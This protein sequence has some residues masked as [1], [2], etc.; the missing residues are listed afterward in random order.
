[1]KLNVIDQIVNNDL[2]IGCGICTVVCPQK[3]LSIQF[4]NYG[5]YIAV[6][7]NNCT[8]ECGLCLKVC[9]FSDGNMN[10]TYLGAQIFNH[11]EKIKFLPETGYYLD[12]YVGYSTQFRRNGASGGIATWLLTTL[13][14]NDI[15]D[16][17]ICATPHNDPEKLFKLEIFDNAFSVFNSSGSVYYPLEMSQVIQKVLDKSGRYAIT[18]LPCFLKS[19]RLAAQKNTK[20]GERIVISIGLVCGQMKSKYYT[21]YLSELAGVSGELQKVYYRGKNPDKPANNYYFYCM[22][23]NGFEGKIFWDSGVSEAWVNRWF[24]PN[25]CNFCD[26]VFAELADVTVM[27]AWLPE[28]SY[29]NSGTNLVL[30]RSPIV[31]EMISKGIECDEIN[32][33]KISIDKL[34]QS[35]A[36]VL[37]IKR[38]HLGYRLYLAHKN[39]LKVPKK[40]YEVSNNLGFFRNFE[41]RLKNK[42][43][44]ESKNIFVENYQ[45]NC[46]DIE[47]FRSEMKKFIDRGVLCTSLKK[48]VK[49]P[50]RI[51]KKCQRFSLHKIR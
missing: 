22:N 48:L 44:N 31:K 29:D 14:K 2:C 47:K 36:G 41:L 45:K 49:Y 39:G 42:M 34:I 50:K 38:V 26:D 27:D 40:R 32:V 4:N 3:A 16:Y 18:G 43:Q 15:V 10:E 30:V 19:L 35:Q 11:V 51:L 24:T 37:D 17:V 7:K 23:E 28:Y 5:E 25:A 8:N 1:M 12:S 21:T 20:L 33:D 9:P 46:F 13:L 6:K